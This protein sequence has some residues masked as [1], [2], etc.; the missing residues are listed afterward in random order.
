[1]YA[2]TCRVYQK[3]SMSYLS[4]LIAGIKRKIFWNLV[5]NVEWLIGYNFLFQAVP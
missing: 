5:F 2:C 1:M 4:P 3:N